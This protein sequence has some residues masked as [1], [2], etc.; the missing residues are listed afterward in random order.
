M[1]R[2]A[3]PNS[4]YLLL[5]VPLL[6]AL[7]VYSNV[8][9]RHRIREYGDPALLGPLMPTVSVPR[10][11]VKFWLTL[12]AFVCLV[13]VIARPQFGSKMETVKRQGVETVIALD[14]SNSML[15]E[16]VTPS[17][18]AKSK[19]LISRLVETFNNDK[20]GLVVFAGDAFTQLPITTDYV[21][22][23]MFLSSINPSLI[24]TQG[25]DIGAAIRL[26]MKSFTPAEG[27]GRAIVV[28]TDGEN[29]EGGAVEAA[30]EAAEKDMRVFVLGVGS[31]NGSPI[32]TEEGSQDFR[33]DN[34]GNVIVTRLN[35]QMCQEIAQA[36]NG[37]YVRVDNSNN[38][39]KTLNEE[40]AKLAKNDVES[41]VYTEFDEQFQVLAW[42]ALV[43]LVVEMLLLERKNPLFKNVRIFK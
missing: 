30:K 13:F 11:N 29:H 14:I 10:M 32:P 27:V 3:E 2:F 19:K 36:G 35:E 40:I 43:L 38:A 9:R 4:L 5:L 31:P 18:L 8:R 25:T 37:V 20:V 39:E 33:R 28:I 7:Y 15:A 6:I 17:R 41:Q 26:A 21:S 16:D 34:E 12:A 23:K 42:M 22:A 1:F 24:T